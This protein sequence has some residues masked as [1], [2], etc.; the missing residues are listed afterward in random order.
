MIEN[1]IQNKLIWV[2]FVVNIITL[3]LVITIIVA[4]RNAITKQASQSQVKEKT[5]I[6]QSAQQPIFQQQQAQQPK[7]SQTNEQ[8][9]GGQKPPTNETIQG[10]C[11]D[12]I[13]QPIEKEKDICPVDCK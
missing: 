1:K 9:Q 4:N 2:M 13:C 7:Q 8:Q 11:G 5:Q 12:N 3:I 6:Q 10:K